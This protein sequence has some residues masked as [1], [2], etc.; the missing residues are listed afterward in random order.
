MARI[1]L[2]SLWYRISGFPGFVR[3]MSIL[4]VSFF[5]LKKKKKKKKKKNSARKEEGK[6]RT[7]KSWQESTHC[8]QTSDNHLQVHPGRIEGL[9]VGYT[10]PHRVYRQT[11][12]VAVDVA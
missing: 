7:G 5:R 2:G 12:Q 9:D 1:H 6:K 11:F 8:Y 10:T 4:C 3:L